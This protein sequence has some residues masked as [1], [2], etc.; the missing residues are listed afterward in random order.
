MF[1]KAHPLPGI[2]DDYYVWDRE[3]WRVQGRRSGR[4]FSLGDSI[5]VRLIKTDAEKMEIDLVM[6]ESFEPRSRSRRGGGRPRR[7][8][9]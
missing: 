2:D 3:K 4:T 7:R 1:L 5:K 8:R 9:R 6:S